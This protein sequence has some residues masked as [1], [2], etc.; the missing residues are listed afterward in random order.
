MSTY[1]SALARLLRRRSPHIPHHIRFTSNLSLN[2]PSPP[3][4][5]PK[6]QQEFEDLVRAA[7]TPAA[8]VQKGDELHPDARTKP[9]PEFLGDVNPATGEVGGPKYEPLKHGD[10]S[11][12]GR[13]TDF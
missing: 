7:E 10:W 11:F 4:L 12:G 9:P 5:P 13:T 2:R 6:E 3:P 1:A 8:S